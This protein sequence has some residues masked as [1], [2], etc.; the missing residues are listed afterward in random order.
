[1]PAAIVSLLNVLGAVLASRGAN[2]L[3]EYTLLAATLVREGADASL[4]LDGLVAEIQEMV[5]EGREP[6]LA[7]VEAVS[8][9]RQALSA[10]IQD[11]PP[12]G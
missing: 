2:Q 9:R 8:A 1:M 4:E 11:D 3:S 12:G 10:A 7:E 5:D 6:T